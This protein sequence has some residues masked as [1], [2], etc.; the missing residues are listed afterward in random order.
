MFRSIAYSI[1]F[2]LFSFAYGQQSRLDSLLKESHFQQGVNLVN[3]YNEI[4]WEYKSINLDSSLLFS[5]KAVESARKTS[6][7][8]ALASAYNSLASSYEAFS[9]YDSAIVY[10]LKS[11]HIKLNEGDSIG[12]AN[13][14]NN[15]GIIH[16]LKGAYQ[17]SLSYYF[18]ALH[19]Y[20]RHADEFHKVPMVYVNIGIV[21]K[22]LKEY[23][24]VLVFYKKAI[25]IYRD[26]NY[27]IGEVITTGNMSTIYLLKQQY[28]ST[29]YFAQLAADLYD[30]LGYKR[31]I[32]YM[33]SNIAIAKDSLKEYAEAE[34]IYLKINSEFVADN[35]WNELSAN[36]INLA[37][38]YILNEKIDL[39][40]P[41][42]QNALKI[43]ILH[44]LK[45]QEIR[46]YKY[47]AIAFAKTGIFDKAYQYEKKYTVLK[48]SIFD[49]EKTKSLFEL[50]AKYQNEK[51][52]KLLLEEKEKFQ[53]SEKEKA[54]Q[55]LII[56]RKNNW[57]LILS[58]L[59]AVGILFTILLGQILIRKKEK[60]KNDA[61]VLEKHN[62]LNA[63]IN[64]QEEER[65]RIAKD[66]H[67]GIGQK[68]S[69]IKMALSSFSK[70]MD[71]NNIITQE[72]IHF[73]ENLVEK[74]AHET[75]SL[76]HQMMPV[77]L[78]TAGLSNTL[79]YLFEESFKHA[80][81]TYSFET[82][83]LKKDIPSSIELVYYRISQELVN[84][85]LKHSRATEVKIQL[86]QI[87]NHLM[88]TIT[89]N[90]IGF[91]P[92]QSHAGLGII[93][94]E[95]RLK[96]IDGILNIDSHEIGVSFTAKCKI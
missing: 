74:S 88:L 28:D 71:G 4:S 2:F 89:D 45:E 61:L 84:N 16:D 9:A 50:E 11:L 41:L 60:E 48:D 83:N 55:E 13:S 70:S 32:A 17:T 64:A 5:K 31:Y 15:L 73:I 19:L 29:I 51:K 76:S 63:I 56:V 6:S 24:K 53:T 1:P 7:S 87:N 8:I 80:E 43:S 33:L 35:N 59:I 10:H 26:N 86:Y 37:N 75:R 54:Q 81:I 57:I 67:D 69:S 22:Q 42:L 36:Q 44:H 77:S 62:S 21:Y 65:S 72:K 85:I 66:L 79:A 25:N 30:S 46:A 3:T 49:V 34:K 91:T 52:E 18:K 94:I 58:S 12:I 47:L 95:T 68:L 40:I 82:F 93:N 14:Y 90:G 23:D 78:K 96:T 38:N 92:N 39:A 27:L 20:E